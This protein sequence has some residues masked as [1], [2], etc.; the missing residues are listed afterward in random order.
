MELTKAAT[1]YDSIRGVLLHPDPETQIALKKFQQLDSSTAF[2][3]I[4]K[5][6]QMAD[7]HQISAVE[8]R[9]CLELLSGFIFRRYICGES[10]RPYAQWFVSACKEVGATEPVLKLERFLTERGSFPSDSRFEA[11]FSGFEL[12]GKKYAFDVLQQLEHSFGNKEAPNA[13]QATIEHIM[14]QMLS[15][16]WKDDLGPNA[17]EIREQWL[18]TV[19]NLTFSGYN[20]GLTNKRFSMKL[21]GAGE[22][23]GY[24]KSN[25]ELTKMVLENSKWGAKEIEAR[26]RE[27]AQRATM[28]WTGPNLHTDAAADGVLKNPFAEGGTRFKLFNILADGQWHSIATIKEQYSWDVVHRVGRF[29]YLGEKNGLWT[30]EESADKVRM[31]SPGEHALHIPEAEEQLTF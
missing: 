5:L 13:D 18:H 17:K 4:L 12:Y 7:S 25:F 23:L 14:P 1:L 28:I 19:G 3:L 26:G 9:T 10:S 31:R 16:E 30:I 29:K 20:S 6:M 27:L 15:K 22:I 8:L 11:A 21:Q 2:P 24:I